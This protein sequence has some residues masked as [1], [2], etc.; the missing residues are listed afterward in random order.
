MSRQTGTLDRVEEWHEKWG[1]RISVLAS[2][3]NYSAARGLLDMAEAAAKEPT[4]EDLEPFLETSLADA[5]I[6]ERSLAVL[7]KTFEA[8][9]VKDLLGIST[10]ALLNA[11]SCGPKTIDHIW[12]QIMVLADY[13]DYLRIQ[14]VATSGGLK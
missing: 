4:L 14:A 11:P 8:I 9:Y 6:D 7:D 2:Q 13:R 10:T 1:G 12:R 3:G 5:G